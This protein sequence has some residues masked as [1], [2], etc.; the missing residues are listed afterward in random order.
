MRRPVAG[1]RR[2]RQVFLTARGRRS[3]RKLVP[4]AQDVNAIAARGVP[5]ADVAATRRTLLALLDNLAADDARPR[6][7]RGA[8]RRRG[9]SAGASNGQRQGLRRGTTTQ[10]EMSM[11][12]LRLT[13]ACWSYDR[14]R[15]LADG[16][17]APEGIDLNCLDLPVEETFF[18]MLRHREF[19]VAEMSLSSYSVTLA[20]RRSAVHRDPGVPVA[21]VPALVHLRRRRRAASAS[22]RTSSASASAR[23]N[24]R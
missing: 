17:V 18:R 23:R 20:P 4:L 10:P 16:S 19:D 9:S 8:F 3:R 13:F 15:A 7:G 6:D 24:T 14:T 5:A 12:K 2:K 22:R 11:A 21:H 1:D